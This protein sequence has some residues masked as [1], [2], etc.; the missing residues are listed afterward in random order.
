MEI[1]SLLA[2]WHRKGKKI[3][4]V[5]K[6]HQIKKGIKCYSNLCLLWALMV[7]GTSSCFRSS[8]AFQI[9]SLQFSIPYCTSCVYSTGTNL[10]AKQN[11]LAKFVLE[12]SSLHRYILVKS[13]PLKVSFLSVVHCLDPVVSSF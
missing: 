4:K 1:G 7:R 5:I 8:C 6:K 12:L 13:L 10:V 9:R 11:V 2:K 3:F